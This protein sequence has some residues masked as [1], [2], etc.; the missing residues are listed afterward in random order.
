MENQKV[1]VSGIGICEVVEVLG[2]DRIVLSDLS[3]SRLDFSRVHVSKC[4]HPDGPEAR[5]VQNLVEKTYLEVQGIGRVLLL[6]ECGGTLIVEDES[7]TRLSLPASRCVGY[8]FGEGGEVSGMITPPPA[9]P[10]SLDDQF[11]GADMGAEMAAAEGF[12][13]S[14]MVAEPGDQVFTVVGKAVVEWVVE[15]PGG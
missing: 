9:D 6:Q 5:A 4:L 10:A 1:F 11:T 15:T 8:T 3:I 2:D 12:N 14:Q 13:H 7:G